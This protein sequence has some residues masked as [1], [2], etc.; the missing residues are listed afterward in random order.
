MLGVEEQLERCSTD[1]IAAQIRMNPELESY[2]D[3]LEQFIRKYMSW[4]AVEPELMNGYIERL[5][6]REAEELAAFLQTP[7]G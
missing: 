3:I 7:L 2:R 5:S 1:L 4:T 6:Q